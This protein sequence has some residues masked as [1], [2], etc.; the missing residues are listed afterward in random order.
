[1]PRR[2]LSFRHTERGVAY[3]RARMEQRI[4]EQGG[5]Y[6]RG[7]FML[8]MQI[9]DG[10]V[11]KAIEHL[12]TNVKRDWDANKIDIITQASQPML[13]AIRPQ[14]PVSKKEHYRYLTNKNGKSVKITYKPGHLR[15]SVKILN[16]YKPR[17]RR[18][19]TLVLGPLKNYP[20]KMDRG[21]FDGIK[22]SDA[23]YTNFVFGGANEFRN[24]AL[25]HG[26]LKT[27]A[28]VGNT[29]IRGAESIIKRESIAAG[30]Q[31][32]TGP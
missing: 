26:F 11:Q 6:V 22:K 29:I 1:M 24:I 20:T 3:E 32:T 7:E 5:K 21:P 31:Y 4:A 27:R 18:I 12:R 30:I 10:E 13:A 23:Y 9:Y 25:L 2:P 14:I 15:N 28:L 16:T 17:L 8:D 19:D